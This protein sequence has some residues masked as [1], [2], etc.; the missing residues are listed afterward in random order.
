MNTAVRTLQSWFADPRNASTI[1]FGGWGLFVALLAGLVWVA[2][3]NGGGS[4]ATPMGQALAG[5]AVAAL[6]TAIG[7][8]PALFVRNISARWQSATLKRA[9]DGLRELARGEQTRPS[10]NRA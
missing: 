1:E 10:P 4:L 2:V 3:V 9:R 5:S 6:A 7:A 8:A